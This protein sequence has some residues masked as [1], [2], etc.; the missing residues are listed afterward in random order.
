MHSLLFFKFA[1]N[2]KKT[3]RNNST[4]LPLNFPS[5]HSGK[6]MDTFKLLS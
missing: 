1:K 6:I 2:F 4:S 3:H 5:N